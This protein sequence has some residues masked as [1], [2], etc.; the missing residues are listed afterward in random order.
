MARD[1]PGCLPP[2]RTL[3]RIRWPVTAPVPRPPHRLSS[4]ATTSGR[5]SLATLGLGRSPPFHSGVCRR[6]VVSF[7]PT[8]LPT[9]SRRSPRRTRPP[10]TR[11]ATLLGALRACVFGTR[12][13][14]TTS[15]TAFRRTSN[16]T[17][18]LAAPCRD[19]GH[20]LLPFLIHHAFPLARAVTDGKPRIRP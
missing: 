13:R 10:F 16:Q 14:L 2:S 7:H 20:D 8:R 1:D 5:R 4:D 17:G 19:E 6:T 11:T 3:R 9:L 18:A 15:A 12:H